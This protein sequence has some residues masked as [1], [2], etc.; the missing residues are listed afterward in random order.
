[1][2]R[3]IEA[4]LTADGHRMTWA[5]NGQEAIRY[6]AEQQFDLVLTDIMMPEKDGLEIIRHL[7]SAKPDL[8]IIAMSGSGSAKGMDYLPAAQAFGAVATLAKPFEPA[9]LLRLLREHAPP[10]I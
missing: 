4:V 9:D 1:M 10:S 8:A 7:R 3:T 5:R 6:L 2:A